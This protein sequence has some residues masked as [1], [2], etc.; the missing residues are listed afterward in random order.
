MKN[1]NK[2]INKQTN[3]AFT[4][5]VCVFVTWT[6]C[7]QTFRMDDMCVFFIACILFDS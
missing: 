4:N 6:W 2:Y 3:F 7:E 1:L 5:L